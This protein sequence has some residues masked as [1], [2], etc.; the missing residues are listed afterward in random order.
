MALQ[1]QITL[2]IKPFQEALKKL[3]AEAAKLN[4]DMQKIFASGGKPLVPDIKADPTDLK[5]IEEQIQGLSKNSID[6]DVK[7]SGNGSFLSGFKNQISEAKDAASQGGGLFGNLATGIGTLLSPVGLATAGV[8]LLTTGM[9][10]VFDVGQEFETGLQAV[11]AVTGLTGDSL[12]DL[13]D[14]AKDLAVKFGGDASTQLSSFQGILSRF[15]ADLAKTP[16]A[17]GKVSESVNLLAK[18]GGLDAASAMDTLT[19]SMLQFGVDV[20]NP[21]EAAKES[22]RFT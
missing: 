15:G 17:L 16:D 9:K 8:G 4:A 7:T 22:A 19:N 5:K 14:R 13:G 1:E 12:N 11:S 21:N 3:S 6:L 18:A 20:A 2:D 10:A